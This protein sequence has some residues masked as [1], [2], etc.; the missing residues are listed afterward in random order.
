MK[1][2]EITCID[3]KKKEMRNSY[4]KRCHACANIKIRSYTKVVER[5][6]KKCKICGTMYKGTAIEKEFCTTQCHDINRNQEINKN[7]EERNLKLKFKKKAI[8]QFNT[9]I[10]PNMEI[11]DL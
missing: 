8:N 7:W 2:I 6:M 11:V 3:C 4:T 1:E 5:P 9:R 10:R